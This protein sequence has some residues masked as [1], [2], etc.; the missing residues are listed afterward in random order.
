MSRVN[1]PTV[2]QKPG[3]LSESSGMKKNKLRIYFSSPDHVALDGVIKSIVKAAQ[4]SGVPLS[5]V[6]LPTKRK[7]V[8]LLS[9]PFV[10][11]TSRDQYELIQHVR[12]IEIRQIT[13]NGSGFFDKISVPASIRMVVRYI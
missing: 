2:Q 10:Y 1:Q 5:L 9:S 3:V 11:K 7:L 12:M 8:T 4:E 13:A 6:A